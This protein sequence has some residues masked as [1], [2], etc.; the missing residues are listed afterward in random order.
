MGTIEY[1]L[2]I[3][4]IIVTT[5]VAI[6]SIRKTAISNRISSVHSE[7]LNCM[8]EG[9]TYI[10]ETISLLEAISKNVVYY[11]LPGKKYVES[12]FDRYWREIEPIANSFNKFQ[13]KQKFLFPKAL[14]EIMQEI[15]IKLNEA[16]KLVRAL[17]SN[18]STFATDSKPL[19]DKV[20]EIEQIYVDFI[21]SSR[22][23]LGVD[24]ISPISK[25][26]DQLLEVSEFE[27]NK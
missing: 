26:K 11:K 16:K 4:G 14:Y 19:R 1:F 18:S 22:Q 3:A 24:K 2:T 7:M 6:Y 12:A 9:T 20:A 25:E 10:R 15:I 13:S 23:Y 21:H 27:E 5:I 17:D 8:V